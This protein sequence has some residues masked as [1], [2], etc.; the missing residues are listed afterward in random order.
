MKKYIKTRP[1][2]VIDVTKIVTIHNYEFGPNFVFRG[3]THDFWELVYI[4]K[5]SVAVCR[6]SEEFILKQITKLY[7]ILIKFHGLFCF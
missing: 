5:G 4:D 3:E 7:F 6:D 1:K 2:T